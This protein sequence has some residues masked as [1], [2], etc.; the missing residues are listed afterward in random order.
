MK[1]FQIAVLYTT[2]L[3][4][5]NNGWYRTWIKPFR[6]EIATSMKECATEGLFFEV[7]PSQG[8]DEAMNALFLKV[9]N[10]PR[11]TM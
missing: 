5:E 7:S 10:M 9:I 11:L 1:N 8:I 6:S 2:Y 4:I 3:S